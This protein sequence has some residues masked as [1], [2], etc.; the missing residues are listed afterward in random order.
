LNE[1]P[2]FVIHKTGVL[3]HNQGTANRY[4]VAA[5]RLKGINNALLNRHFERFVVAALRLKGINNQFV[6]FN[7]L[8]IMPKAKIEPL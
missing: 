3:F 4:V 7:V 1:F 2:V 5:L 8:P 6:L